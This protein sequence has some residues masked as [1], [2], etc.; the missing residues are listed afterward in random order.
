MEHTQR[1]DRVV[2]EIERRLGEAP[3][4]GTLP[5]AQVEALDVVYHALV[6][7]RH[8]RGME[9]WREALWQR[10]L[11]PE[12]RAAVAGMLGHLA[13]AVAR[14]E[15]GAA[16]EVCNCLESFV[17]AVLQEGQEARAGVAGRAEA[18]L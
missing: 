10:R 9:V 2:A 3:E 4:E 14:G 7:E 18:P 6:F 17:G 13:D 11:S 1:A 8:P 16:S 5:A 12:A 15:K